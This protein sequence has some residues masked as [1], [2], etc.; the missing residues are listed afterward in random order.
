VLFEF[1]PIGIVDTAAYVCSGALESAAGPIAALLV[2]WRI[3]SD[4]H[5]L[6]PEVQELLVAY[7]AQEER[8][9]LSPTNTNAS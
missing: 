3:I 6:E 4:E 9:W 1:V 7:V 5:A 2:G 8:L